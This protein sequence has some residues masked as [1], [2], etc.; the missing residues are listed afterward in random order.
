[1]VTVATEEV[2]TVSR[3]EGGFQ[4]AGN[5]TFLDMFAG[6]QGL[7]KWECSICEN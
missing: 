1:M 6:I 2:V 4:D 3:Q 7:I 5:A